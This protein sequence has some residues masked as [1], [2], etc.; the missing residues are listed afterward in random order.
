MTRRPRTARLFRHA[1]KYGAPSHLLRTEARTLDEA[2]E[3]LE[4]RAQGAPSPRRTRREKL[5]PSVA[6]SLEEA[7]DWLVAGRLRPGEAA[8][9]ARVSTDVI[10]EEMYRRGLWEPTYNFNDRA[11]LLAAIREMSDEE[12]ENWNYP[13]TRERYPNWSS[14]AI[15]REI[16]GERT[17]RA[18]RTDR[19]RK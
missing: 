14:V 19:R 1:V 6:W 17:R 12:L 2:V 15:S 5:G 7:V 11:R 10:A 8:R 9:M 4:E 3:I 16:D 18:G 13:S